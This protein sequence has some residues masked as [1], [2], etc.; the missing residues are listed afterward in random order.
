M[1][2]NCCFKTISFQPVENRSQYIKPSQNL[3][4]TMFSPHFLKT[5]PQLKQ[6]KDVRIHG[7]TNKYL[8][9]SW[10]AF[11]CK[12]KPVLLLSAVV[13]KTDLQ[14]LQKLEPWF[15]LA[16]IFVF[17]FEN[18]CQRSQVWMREIAF[19]PK[20]TNSFPCCKKLTWRKFGKDVRSALT[21]LS[22][23]ARHVSRL[24]AKPW[25]GEL[26]QL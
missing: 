18:F 8:Y 1:P 21:Y 7:V 3:C 22:W 15:W 12:S 10:G 9:I 17:H 16:A 6:M 14:M 4:P 25:G 5:F 23:S 11:S 2:L 13:F 20:P 19:S 26:L 24:L